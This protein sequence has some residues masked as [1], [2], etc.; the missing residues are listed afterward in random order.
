MFVS[1]FSFLLLGLTAGPTA[2]P[3][4]LERPTEVILSAILLPIK[5]PVA[6]V[7]LPTIF[8][9]AIVAK[10]LPVFIAVSVNFLPYLLLKFVPVFIAVFF[11]FLPYLSP[12]FCANDKNP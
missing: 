4:S 8:L 1:S 5:F 3:S 11:N 9:P 2:E 12:K 6:S 10:S 7:L